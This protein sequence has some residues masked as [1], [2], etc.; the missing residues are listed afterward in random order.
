[1]STALDDP[2]AVQHEDLVHRFQRRHPVRD[3]HGRLASSRINQVLHQCAGRGGIQVLL[4]LVQDENREPGEEDAS[5]AYALTLASRH[6]GAVFAHLCVEPG[7]KFGYPVEETGSPYGQ[8]H[9]LARGVPLG[10]EQILPQR[11]VENMSV[12]SREPDYSPNVLT[13]QLG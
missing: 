10:Q 2:A 1:M 5:H 7:G 12:L 11:G 8:P 4:W 13:G 3:H 6:P 9:G